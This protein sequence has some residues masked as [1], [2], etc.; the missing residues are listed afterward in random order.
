MSN[1][2]II[3][4]KVTELNSLLSCDMPRYLCIL[5]LDVHLSTENRRFDALLTGWSKFEGAINVTIFTIITV[6]WMFW[7]FWIDTQKN[8]SS[9]W[10]DGSRQFIGLLCLRGG[11][12]THQIFYFHCLLKLVHVALFYKVRH[13][14]AK[15]LK[16][17]LGT[18]ETTTI[19]S[20]Y[21]NFSECR[22]RATFIKSS[23]LLLIS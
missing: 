22:H 15:F 9:W 14:Q 16:Y 2:K 20:V 1:Y 11:S 12:F 3:V 5:L 7:R 6:F 13:I 18:N 23:C 17:V 19:W 21:T 8:K 4:G 10:F